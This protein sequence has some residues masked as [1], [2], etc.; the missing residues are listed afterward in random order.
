M[1]FLDT[2]ALRLGC[3]LPLVPQTGAI[4][5]DLAY[6][7]A[8]VGYH[9]HHIS[10]MELCRC[11]S[12]PLRDISPEQ[13]TQAVHRPGPNTHAVRLD[14]GNLGKL[15]LPCVL[16]WDFNHFVVFEA[17]DGCGVVLHDLAH[18]QRQLGLGEVSQSL[19]GVVLELWPENSF[20]KQ[21]AS[22][23]IKLLN[24]LGEVTRLHRSLAQVLLLV[25]VLEVFSPVSPFFLQ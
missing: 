7:V 4:E 25:S 12:V 24:M 16:Y 5:C 20:E 19:I 23:R 22:L 3:R 6:L 21:E 11:F 8:I 13:L 1:V 10:L 2:L 9:G 14:L 17:I 18:G 15:R